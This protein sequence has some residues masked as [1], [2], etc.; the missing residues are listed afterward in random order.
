MCETQEWNL[1]LGIL[2]A[3]IR[4]IGK[5]AISLIGNLVN[6]ALGTEPRAIIGVPIAGSLLIYLLSRRVRCYRRE[7]QCMMLNTRSL[8]SASA[9]MWKTALLK[10]S[11]VHGL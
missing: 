8:S 2:V 9:R 3:G 11:A 4:S 6:V 5:I 1:V 10:V 7:V